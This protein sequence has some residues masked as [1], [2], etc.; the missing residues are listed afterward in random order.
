MGVLTSFWSWHHPFSIPFASVSVSP[1]SSRFPKVGWLET[2]YPVYLRTGEESEWMLSLSRPLGGQHCCVFTKS[3]S[4]FPQTKHISS[5]RVVS[6]FG[7]ARY[8][9]NCNCEISFAYYIVR[10]FYLTTVLMCLTRLD[11]KF[12]R[13]YSFTSQRNDQEFSIHLK[14]P[15]HIPYIPNLYN[16]I[17]EFGERSTIRYIAWRNPFTHTF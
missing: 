2:W 1:L 14:M 9:D 13:K 16:W 12:W 11:I 3:R 6:S 4:L 7:N 10:H 5:P 17:I 8:T 15:F